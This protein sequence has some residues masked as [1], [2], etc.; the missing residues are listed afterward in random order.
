M[1]KIL[2]TTGLPYANGPLHLGHMIGQIQADIWVR[3]QRMCGHD[4]LFISGSDCH[5]APIM[6]RAKKEGMA[7]EAWIEKNREEQYND[8]TAF[9]VDFDNYY[10]THSPE[11]QTLTEAIFKKLNE[12]G[13]IAK[14]S[15]KQA[16][17]PVKKLF[18]ADR[19]V[20][21]TCPFCG[22]ED[23]YGD[24]CEKCGTTYT[25]LDLK[26]PIS[27]LSGQPPIIKSSEHYFFKLPNHEAFLKE[28]THAGHIDE[29]AMHRCVAR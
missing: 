27:V 10:H 17:D 6:I 5:G 26:N 22:A 16:Y 14:R 9:E 2:V 28:W 20:K 24:G 8:L 21:G 4:C 19:Y 23:Q 15:V 13:D 11:T 29:A 7:P 18:L 12:Q 25:P 3:F 1:R